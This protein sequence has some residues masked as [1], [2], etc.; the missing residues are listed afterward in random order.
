M[1]FS[2]H[3]QAKDGVIDLVGQVPGLRGIDV[4]GLASA[5]AVE[6]L[7]AALVE[8]NRRYKTHCSLQVT[9]VP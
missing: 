8:V 2:D 6:A 5:L 9:G 4:G 1:V 7:T 3:R